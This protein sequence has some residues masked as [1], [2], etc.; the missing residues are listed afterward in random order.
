MSLR[1]QITI[2]G[3]GIAGLSA[4]IALARSG[5]RV[6]VFEQQEP[7]QQLGAGLTLWSNAVNALRALDL[8]AAVLD[9]GNPL[10][11]LS[12]LDPTGRT[13]GQTDAR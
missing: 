11:K 10:A 6:Q 7:V 2:I 9:I 5:H 4:A 8:E 12:I 3:A 13:L 1:Y